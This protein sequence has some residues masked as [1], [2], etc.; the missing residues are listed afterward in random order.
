MIAN[1]I[2]WENTKLNLEEIKQ[3]KTNLLSKPFQFCIDLTGRCNINPPC[4]F[5]SLKSDGYHYKA[6]NISAVDAYSDFLSRCERLV[7]CSFGEPL[8]HPD[9]F[10]LVQKVAENG[11]TF[12]FATNGLLLTPQRADI[13]AE[14]GKNVVFSISINAATAETYH[15]LTG[16]SFDRVI[17]N[18]KYFIN[19]YKHKWG[20]NP[21]ALAANF[22]VM[23][24]NRNEVAD[25]LRLMHSLGIS[26]LNLRHLLDMPGART[27]DDFGYKFIYSDEILT[28]EEYESVGN[29][30]KTLAQQLGIN[31][32]I[33]W[34]TS[35]AMNDFAVPGVDI[36]CLFPWKYLFVQE[37]S[38]NVYMCGY[39]YAPVGSVKTDSLEQ[40]WN[41]EIMVEVRS[42]LG[43]GKI[44]E[45]CKS[46]GAFCPLVLKNA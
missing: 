22:I 2:A 31:L 37:H 29:S 19:K 33:H 23:K 4:V 7:D 25:F 6:L 32:I 18:T 12:A 15:K 9:F 21:P 35:S 26:R 3:C 46:H 14:A 44:P 38:K 17:E 40:V 16:K 20:H 36:P 13:L 5:C 34:E 8:T 41:N 1:Y 45:F 27:R 24:V 10:K 43:S 11:Q 30:A 42:S 28:S 39:S